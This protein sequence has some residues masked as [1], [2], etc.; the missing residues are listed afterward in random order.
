MRRLMSVIA[1]EA[2]A[3]FF[4]VMQ[5][6]GHV[7][8]DEAKY[9]LN[10]P[11]PHPPLVR[12]LLSLFDGFP[13]QEVGARILFA[14]IVTQAAWLAWGMGRD[15]IERVILGAS[16]LLCW[17]TL[18]Q[19][20]TIMMA[21]LT[22]VAGL[23]FLWSYR[24]DAD[25]TAYAGLIALF[26]LASL[27]TAYQSFLFFPLVCA[28]F[29]RMK[30][31]LWKRGAYVVVPVILLSLY[32]LTNPLALASII[33]RAGPAGA[34]PSAQIDAFLSL[35][36]LAGNTMIGVMG[37]VG[38][39]MSGR[40]AAIASYLLVCLY[41]FLG[42]APYYAVLFV[43]FFV[44]G[45]PSLSRLSPQAPSAVGAVVIIS[46]I[47]MLSKAVV[48]HPP[49]PARG[50]M[51]AITALHREGDILI[52]GSFGH[53]WQYE[54]SFPTYRYNDVLL[55]DAQ[56]VICLE[57]TCGVRGNPAFV[58]MTQKPVEVWIRE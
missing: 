24:R 12:W 22:A 39:A 32:T 52:Q 43:P 13:W 54:S 10:I 42:G 30:L 16:W 28:L 48:F 58:Q 37:T 23:F 26:W 2:Y 53:D 20:G 56:A 31:P 4:A 19:T 34:D 45:L 57:E 3:V 21:P 18:S 41:V 1:L 6:Q 7:H 15:R 8:T 14:S 11:Y 38:L 40:K 51:Q 35:W 27:F 50:V 29:W 55:Q 49:T 17:G 33:G 36:M 9:L 44:V 47:T 5:S 46:A 25:D